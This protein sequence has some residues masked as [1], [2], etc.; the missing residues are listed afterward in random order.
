[1]T[2]DPLNPATAARRLP[3]QVAA[4]LVA[5]AA[6]LAGVLA[7]S[8]DASWWRG[9]LAAAVVSIL[10]AA[11]SLPP[12][13]WGLRQSL[14]NAVAAYFLAAA[15]RATISLGGCALAVL[16]GNYPRTATMLLM[17]AFYFAVLAIESITVGR[18]LWSAKLTTLSGGTQA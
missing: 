14:T 4:A 8:N 6:L 16:K 7:L 1:M 9:Y 18:A 10:A 2:F 11:A 15:I 12:L 17:V 13:V 5:T 3:I